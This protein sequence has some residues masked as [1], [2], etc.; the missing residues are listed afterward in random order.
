[1]SG[2]QTVTS[3]STEDGLPIGRAIQNVPIGTTGASIE[4]PI[5]VGPRGEGESIFALAHRLEALLSGESNRTCMKVLNMVGSLHGIRCIPADRPIG[6][7]TAGLERKAPKPA[8]APKGKPTQKAAWKQT[9]EYRELAGK[10]AVLVE[11]LK[12]YTR[13]PNHP[14]TDE[15]LEDLRVT[16]RQ[17][18][19]LRSPPTAGDD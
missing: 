14:M 8:P 7:S 11:L 1:M 10:R 5:T 6:Q 15:T 16:E 17:L 18:K 9:P 4:A 2:N 13:S 3:S 19:A 12:G